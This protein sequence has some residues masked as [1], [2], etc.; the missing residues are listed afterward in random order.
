MGKIEEYLLWRSNKGMPLHR[1][2]TE[3]A[4]WKM[5]VCKG[6]GVNPVLG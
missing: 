4:H 1:E 2:G 3:M 5:V 6:K